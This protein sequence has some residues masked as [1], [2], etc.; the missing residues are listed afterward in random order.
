MKYSLGIDTSNYKTSVALTDINGGIVYDKRILLNVDKGK[1]GL[2]QQEA[3]FQHINNLP[4]LFD[5]MFN[6]FDT[7]DISCVSVSDKPR[8]VSG[9]YM[10]AFLAGVSQAKVL[11]GSLKCPLYRFSHQDGHV[12][13]A[14]RFTELCEAKRFISL[15]F[16]GGT[17][18]ILLYDNGKLTIIGG[19]KDISFGQLLDR[20]G[21][22]LGLD[23]PCGEELDT[24]AYEYLTKN[25]KAKIL[26]F[27]KIKT[28]SGYINLS[29]IESAVFRFIDGKTLETDEK[30]HLILG[31]FSSISSAILDILEDVYDGYRIN[32]FLFAGGVS[33]S[34]T[35]RKMIGEAGTNFNSVF[36][37][38]ELS[39]DNAIGISLLGGEKIWR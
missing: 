4:I 34:K 38:P 13:A 12:R 3:L 37:E 24:L 9:S 19:T 10:P 33:S 30:N 1:R 7:K 21:T 17:T 39:S 31:V 27:P 29:G 26:V 36:C 32:D 25:V 5:D 22:K 23:F 16:S 2:R 20:I 8:S 15:H 35:L 14:S 6:N 11:A 18:E 28:N